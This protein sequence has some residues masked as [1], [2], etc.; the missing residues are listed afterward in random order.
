M[1]KKF[2]YS[3]HEDSRLWVLEYETN[4]VAPFTTAVR[5]EVPLTDKLIK[6]S[7]MRGVIRRIV[8]RLAG[9]GGFRAE[10]TEK[11]FGTTP[12]DPAYIIYEDPL[13]VDYVNKIFDIPFSL[14]ENETPFAPGIGMFIGITPTSGS[15]IYKVKLYIDSRS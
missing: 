7:P 11:A 15:G 10:I 9:G 1:S 2:H 4:P 3:V 14:E 5:N 6:N 13:V 12:A 8:I